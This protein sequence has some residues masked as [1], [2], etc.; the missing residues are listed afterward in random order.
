MTSGGRE[1]TRGWTVRSTGG[2]ERGQGRLQLVFYCS[3]KD[4]PEGLGLLGEQ[5]A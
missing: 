2:M 1:A 4:E 3:T 5:R